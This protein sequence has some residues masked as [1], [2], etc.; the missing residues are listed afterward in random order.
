MVSGGESAGMD[1]CVAGGAL[2]FHIGALQA[3]GACAMYS[4]RCYNIP[5]LIY[6]CSVS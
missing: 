5:T 3:I 2:L 1:I 4:S 6:T